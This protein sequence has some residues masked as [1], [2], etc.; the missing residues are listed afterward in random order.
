MVGTVERGNNYA[1]PYDGAKTAGHVRRVELGCSHH[2]AM[3]ANNRIPGRPDPF[4]RIGERIWHVGGAYPYAGTSSHAWR[5]A[6]M[7]CSGSRVSRS[8]GRSSSSQPL[9][10]VNHS[11]VSQPSRPYGSNTLS[12][13]AITG[14]GCPSVPNW[15]VGKKGGPP[16]VAGEILST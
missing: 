3:A 13:F 14:L 9:L 10:V 11:A 1:A 16:G 5:A 4:E 6:P 15:K 12:T 8:T 2:D 7:I